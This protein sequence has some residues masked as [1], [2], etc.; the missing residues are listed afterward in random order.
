M[1]SSCRKEKRGVKPVKSK[2]EPFLAV[3]SWA[4]AVAAGMLVLMRCELTPGPSSSPQYHWPPF[5]FLRRDPLHPTLVMAV[6]PRCACA[7]ASVGEL[8]HIVA[9]S[10]GRLA[11]KILVYKPDGSDEGWERTGLWREAAAMPGVTLVTDRNGV[12]AARFHFS[13]SGQVLLFDP[14]GRLL[15]DGGIP[16]A[17]GRAGSNE[18]EEAV[19]ALAS[20]RE[21][22]RA[23]TPAFGCSL[24]GRPSG[25]IRSR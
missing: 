18:G 10:Q 1:L 25:T 24:L 21:A 14:S 3:F 5:T 11:V 19:A 7:R 22:G 6:H 12:E 15:F 9:G 16:A 13:T 2:M 23:R 8:A 20:G 17:R 4:A